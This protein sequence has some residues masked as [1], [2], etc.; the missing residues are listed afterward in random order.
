MDEREKRKLVYS[1]AVIAGLF[2]SVI[3]IIM[4]LNFWQLQKSDPIESELLKSL[5]ERLKEDQNNEELREDIRRLDLMNRKAYFTKQWQI[6]AGAYMLIAGAVILVMALRIYHSLISK[7]EEPESGERNVIQ[8]LLSSQRWILYSAAAVFGLALTA[9]I[10]SNDHLNKTYGLT[11]L[12]SEKDDDIQEITII[13]QDGDTD[14]DTAL[15]TE[16]PESTDIQDPAVQD[17]ETLPESVTTTD[18]EQ[19]TTTQVNTGGLQTFPSFRGKYSQGISD[20]KNTP[21]DWDGASGKNVIWKAAITS[22]GYNSPVIWGDRLFLTGADATSQLVYCYNRNNGEVMWQQSLDDIPRPAGKIREPSGDTGYA[23]PTVTTDGRFVYA[24]FATGDVACL[25]M[26]GKRIWAKNLGIPDNHYGHSSSLLLHE[27]L[28]IVQFDTSV[29]GKVLGLDALTGD[30]KWATLRNTQISWASPVLAQVNGHWELILVSSPLVASY[31]PVTGEEL[32]GLECLMGEVGASAGFDDGIVYAA[33]EY[34]NLVA[35]KPGSNP[36]ILWETNEYLPEV[37]SPVAAKGM[38]FVA[39]SYGV[40]ACYDA[41][42][43]EILWEHECDQGLYAS[44]MIADGKVYFL[45]MDG[46]MHIFN[47]DKT[48][49]LLG[50]PQ[51]GE[52]SVSTPAFTDGRIYLRSDKFLYCLGEK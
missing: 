51:L 12:S 49:T 48:L 40:I 15:P 50:E 30:Q 46:I 33:N 26:N 14:T 20:H 52:N 34:A 44:P 16:E 17:T 4:I 8:E 37:A 43:G 29:S 11:E 32:W 21:V 47:V 41:G 1:I 2:T 45:D 7:V 31:N 19:S 38:V 24:I 18:T 28:L 5:V 10:L 39:T 35:I 22:P 27:G 6:R 36:E 23:A 25:D 3:S 42:N 13:A 9:A